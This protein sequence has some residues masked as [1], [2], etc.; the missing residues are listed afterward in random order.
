MVSYLCF[1][2]FSDSWIGLFIVEVFIWIKFTKW[3]HQ[4]QPVVLLFFLKFTINIFVA[5][6]INL[7][8]FNTF[9]GIAFIISQCCFNC[10]QIFV[11]MVVSVWTW[12]STMD[13]CSLIRTSVYW[14]THCWLP[15]IPWNCNGV[16]GG[17]PLINADPI[18]YSQYLWKLI[19]TSSV[20]IASG[21]LKYLTVILKS[22][23]VWWGPNFYAS[24][25]SAFE[26]CWKSWAC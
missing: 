5:K 19:R 12:I 16:D 20:H 13:F 23:R 21:C 24:Q 7:C 8:M 9:A 2:I 1:L 15:A 4:M 17:S 3:L 26:F 10:S 22:V 18:T 25:S 14:H 6:L 11:E